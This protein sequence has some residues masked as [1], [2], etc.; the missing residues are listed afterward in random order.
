MRAVPQ[1]LLRCAAQAAASERGSQHRRGSAR[2][3]GCQG[4]R[5]A[6][7]LGRWYTRSLTPRP[8]CGARRRRR[9][10]MAQRP[11]RGAAPRSLCSPKLCSSAV[12][13]SAGA[14]TAEAG[15]R[16]SSH[17]PPGSAPQTREAAAV[18]QAHRQ[19]RKAAL[20]TK[21][22]IKMSCRIACLVVLGALHTR[23]KANVHTV[24]VRGVNAGLWPLDKRSP[25]RGGAQL[26]WPGETR[27]LSLTC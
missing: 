3:T 5:G 4:S 26:E 8:C 24:Q 27:A 14:A 2:A 23:A 12:R 17:A 25:A 21:E 13:E 19:S 15:P 10:V 1:P 11:G 22:H 18:A 9:A 7:L 16:S 20:S 6:A